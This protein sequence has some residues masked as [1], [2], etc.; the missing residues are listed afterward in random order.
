MK[1]N[2]SFAVFR[3]H[4]YSSPKY[5][6]FLRSQFATKDTSKGGSIQLCIFVTCLGASK[7]VLLKSLSVTCHSFLLVVVVGKQNFKQSYRKNSHSFISQ[8][9]NVHQLQN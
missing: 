9:Q 4:P 3:G 8:T 7:E 6:M 5:W 1:S 2:I